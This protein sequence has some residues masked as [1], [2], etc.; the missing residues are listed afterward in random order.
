MKRGFKTLNY[1]CFLNLYMNM[2][3]IGNANIR[4][5]HMLENIVIALIIPWVLILILYFKD[6]KVLLTIAPF[7]SSIAYTINA[8]GFYFGFWDLYPFGHREIVHVPFDIG[9]YPML[10]AWMVHYIKCKKMSP[11]IWIF[12]F[13]ILTTVIESAGV[14]MGRIVYRKGWNIGWTFISYLIPY[15]LNYVYYVQLKK[16]EV[17]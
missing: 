10:S 8:F 2:T 15:I 7:Q 6:R 13:T 4:G 3:L 17:F 1:E 14:I 5:D 9:I 12:I 11:L 16:S